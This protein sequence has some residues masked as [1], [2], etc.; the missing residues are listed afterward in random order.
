[1]C[2]LP[3]GGT[4]RTPIAKYTPCS[5]GKPS[6]FNN[7]IALATGW[8]TPP[9]EVRRKRKGREDTQTREATCR[10]KQK[11]AFLFVPFL[12]AGAARSSPSEQLGLTDDALDQKAVPLSPSVQGQSAPL[13]SPGIPKVDVVQQVDPKRIS[14]KRI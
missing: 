14:K 12:L 7:T 3:V 13:S 8:T 6:L 11:I 10:R 4:N 5:P 9:W 2:T 1:V